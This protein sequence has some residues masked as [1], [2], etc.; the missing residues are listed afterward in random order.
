MMDITA[1]KSRAR[2][3]RTHSQKQIEQ[4]AASITRFGFINPVLIDEENRII[5][6][7]GHVAGAKRA[8]LKQ[9]PTLRVMALQIICEIYPY[10][11]ISL[12]GSL[13]RSST[14]TSTWWLPCQPG[15]PIRTMRALLSALWPALK[16]R[17]YGRQRAWTR[18]NSGRAL[19]NQE[20]I[21]ARLKKLEL[22]IFKQ[23]RIVS[24]LGVVIVCPSGAISRSVR[25]CT[26]SEG[27]R[28]LPVS[29]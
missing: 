9:V 26:F 21:A 23:K 28:T 6:G 1:L 15:L 27:C 29:R 7:R 16:P 5:A 13:R 19:S 3:P 2:N 12:V 8:G 20:Q 24:E 22:D 11:E 10:P 25:P 14:R 17:R 4:I 18:S